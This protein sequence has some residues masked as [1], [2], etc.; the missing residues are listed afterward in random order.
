MTDNRGRKVR[1]AVLPVA[2]SRH[3][4]PA[5]DQGGP[6]GDAAARRRA[7]LQLD[8]RG[9]RRRRDRGDRLR[10]R[11]RQV[12]P[13]RITSIARPSWRRCSNERGKN[14]TS[15]GCA[16]RPSWRAS[17][18]A[19]GGAARPRARGALRA[20]RRSATSR[21]RCCWATICST[22]RS[23]GI[24]PAR[25][26]LRAQRARAWSRSYEVPP[27]RSTSTASSTASR[28]G[29]A[30]AGSSAADREAGAGDGAVPAGDHRALRAAAGDLRRSSSDTTPGRGGEI[31]LTDALATLCAQSGLHGL[32]GR[33]A[34]LRRRRSRR[35]TCWRWCTTRSTARDPRRRARRVIENCART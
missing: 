21:S 25:R 24:A 12:A 5:G 32:R 26:R 29:A 8:R 9:V 11:A 15:R 30:R 19:P 7:E 14:E 6:E 10:D 23:P 33:G 31:Q 35:A 16:S 17:L 28:D 18:G 3:A 22:R 4:V 1:K 13:S 27:A 34:A 20:R 2:G